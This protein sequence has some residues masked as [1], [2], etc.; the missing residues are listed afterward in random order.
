[1]PE[2]KSNKEQNIL[3]PC[4]ST[5]KAA[6]TLPLR[7]ASASQYMQLEFQTMATYRH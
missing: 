4:L 5:I 1:M 3:R 6:K 7:P 2:T